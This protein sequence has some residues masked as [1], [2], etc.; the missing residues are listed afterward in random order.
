MLG[1][2]VSQVHQAFPGCLDL[3]E[4]LVRK[5]CLGCLVKMEDLDQL[6][7]LDRGDILVLQDLR[8]LQGHQDCQGVMVRKETLGSR[9]SEVCQEIV[10]QTVFLDCQ[11]QKVTEEQVASQDYQ[12]QQGYQAHQGR[13]GNL[14]S[15][16]FQ[17]NQAV[18]VHEA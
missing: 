9:A 5:D 13:M 12:V 2:Q 17:E 18:Q 8:A 14:V 6:V 7:Q 1:Q 11:V 15:G 10:A 16:D 3:R 4:I